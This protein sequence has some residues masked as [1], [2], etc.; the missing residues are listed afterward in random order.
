MYGQGKS[1]RSIVLENHLNKGGEPYTPAEDGEGRERTK[2]NPEQQNED[3]TQSQEATSYN[4]LDRIRQLAKKDRKLRFTA[5]WH[6]VYNVNHLRVA[7]FRLKP[8]AATGVDGETWE[9]YRENLQSNLEDLSS[10]LKRGAYRAKP[11]RRIYIRKEDGRQRPIGIPTLED[12]I[13]QR[14]TVEVLN[15]IYETDF[16]GFSYGFRPGRDAHDALDALAF[17]IETRKVN[18]VLDADIRGFFDT[19]DHE[20]LVKFAEHRIADRRVVRHIQKWLNA[21]V[22]EDGKW[23]EVEEGTPQGGNISPLL[24]N[25]YLHYVLDLWADQW[26]RQWA[27][28]EVYIVR[29]ADDFVVAFQ[30]EKDAE[31]FRQ[32]LRER[33][34]KFNLQLHDE[35][36][37]LLEFGRFA[38]QNRKKRGLGKPETFDFLGFTHIC[39]KTQKGR[40]CVLRKTILKRMA[41]KLRNI[42][43]ELYR[44]MHEPIRE[45]GRWLGSVLRG[46]F[47]Y[48]GVPRNTPSLWRMHFH[49]VRTWHAVLSRRSQKGRVPWTR[50]KQYV[51]RWLPQPCVKHPY[52]SQRMAVKIQGKSRVR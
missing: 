23:M 38:A 27:R 2:E 19:L 21:G 28:G 24:A 18:W 46:H 11:V 12:K 22:M 9:Q 48:Y 47:Q 5:L 50:M 51:K 30:E 36:T 4:A 33:F 40:F 14:V 49:V 29:Y 25:I 13:V 43:A 1:D 32:A 34:Q 52:P 31:A 35:K 10:R 26:R 37:R 8:N 45:V 16:K 7:F 20:W 15:Y 41:A 39:S 42:K 6:H 17:A 44:R 3:W